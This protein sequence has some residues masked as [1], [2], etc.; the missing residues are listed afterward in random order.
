VPVLTC[1]V[2]FRAGDE[3][4]MVAATVEVARLAVTWPTIESLLGVL[5]PAGAAPAGVASW[6]W[7]R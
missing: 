1:E 6:R 2:W 5:L 4:L 3:P 7:E